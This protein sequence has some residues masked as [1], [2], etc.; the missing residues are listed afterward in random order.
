[1]STSTAFAHRGL[2]RILLVPLLFMLTLIGQPVASAVTLDIPGNLAPASS[3]VAGAPTLSWD[4]VTNAKSYT[5]QVS[6]SSGFATTTWTATTVN[7]QIVPTVQLPTGTLH[8]RVRAVN[9][10]DLSDWGVSSFDHAVAAG[11]T[12][13]VPDNATV[14]SQ[15]SQPPVISWDPATGAAGYSVQVSADPTFADSSVTHTYTTKGASL[16]VASLVPGTPYYWRVRSTFSTSIFSDWSA[17]RNFS[18]SKLAKPT[19]VAPANGLSTKVDDVVLDW[20]PVAGAAS[21]DMQ[22]STDP[23]FLGGLV[24]DL[25]SAAGTNY[26]PPTGLTNGAY[27]WRAR[28]IDAQGNK[29]DWSF[30][31]VWSFTRHWPLQPTLEYPANGSTVGDP[32]YYQWTAIRLGDRYTVQL[33]TSA[34]FSAAH[35][36]EE[37]STIGTTYVPAGLG[38]CYPDADGTYYWRVYA[39]D[40][41]GRI[42]SEAQILSDANAAQVFSFTYKN[43]VP[44]LT[45]P[46]AGATV[47]LPTLRWNAVSGASRYKVTIEPT[48]VGELGGGTSFTTGTSFT[49][50]IGLTPGATYRWQVQTVSASGREGSAT[51][52]GNQRTFTMGTPA[53]ATATTPEPTGTAPTAARFPTLTWT[54]V[55]NANNYTVYVRR[56]GTTTW[57]PLESS[58]V[59]PAGEDETPDWLGA[60]TY[61]WKVEAFNGNTFVSAG[62]TTSTFTITTL[63][64]ATGHRV[65]MT[66]QATG[67]AATWCALSAC[68]N[69]RQTPVLAWANDADVSYYRVFVARDVNLTNLVPGYP[70][71][72]ETTKFAPLTTLPDNVAG[73]SYYWGVEPCKANGVCLGL[74]TAP[75][76]F[77]KTSKPVQLLTPVVDAV[78]SNEVTFTWRD[79]LA[80]NQDL[81]AFPVVDSTG[82]QTV[83]PRVEA[84]QYRIQVSASSTFATTLDNQLVDQQSFTTYNNTYPDGALYWRVQA[85]DGSG[86]AMAWSA[87]QKFVKTSPKVNPTSPRNGVIVPGTTQFRWDALNY[88]ASYDIEIYKN[89]DTTATTTNRIVLARSKFPAYSPSTP[90]AVSDVAYVWRV[91]PVDFKGRVGPWTSLVGAGAQFFVNGVAPSLVSPASGAFVESKGA[92]FVWNPVSGATSY[93]LE[94]RTVGSLSAQSTI[95]PAT[96]WATTT[97]LPSGNFQW[98]VSSLDASGRVLASSTWRGYKVDATPP[99]VSTYGPQGLVAK[100]SS[101]TATFSEP[102]NNVTDQTF[103]ITA[104]GATSPMSATVSLSSDR[105]TATLNPGST[106]VIGKKYTVKLGSGIVDDHDNHLTNLTW[107]IT[108]K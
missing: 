7:R 52:T 63:G 31:D 89:A 23:S 57:F 3:T 108:A 19:L 30:V 56:N 33:S 18:V 43:A 68:P 100:G 103:T 1:V 84:K 58:F 35:I 50:R 10:I 32:F 44:T 82:V 28:P 66:G 71:V 70:R 40:N 88:A 105:K 106:L 80:T 17:T 64:A 26:S 77:V 12:G 92:V 86:N 73:A 4:R 67:S 14:F 5:V 13:L 76:S 8:W 22:L 24:V 41:P 87:G 75:N 21:Y 36:V 16:V 69:L 49:P 79:Y 83:A 85:I 78:T 95:T 65:A 27:Y 97:A 93:R 55:V 62:T 20:N 54:P 38:D 25:K 48:T 47:T 39:A 107:T 34:D 6:T 94:R 61:Q 11:P 104:A 53:A 42:G 59:Y 15:P 45:S 29:L 90:L 99:K 72:V 74:V 91:R 9:G 96:S 46:A 81:S 2:A 60:G 101:F 37:C 102:V 51:P 98:R